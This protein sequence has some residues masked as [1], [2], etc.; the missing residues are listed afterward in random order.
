LT[1]PGIKYVETS[2]YV[3][4][5]LKRYTLLC[6]TFGKIRLKEHFSILLDTLFKMSA[7]GVSL[8]GGL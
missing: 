6:S 4:I 1:I 7:D 5:F 8:V 3:S 2:M